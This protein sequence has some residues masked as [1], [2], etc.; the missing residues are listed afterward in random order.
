MSDFTV[1]RVD[2][3]PTSFGGGFVLARASLGVRSFGL[4]VLKM[5]PGAGG[6]EHAHRGM[7]GE[8]AE[9]ANDTRRR[10]ISVSMARRFSC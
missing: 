4:Q 8:R 3:M 2:E 10:S 7:A 6:P 9:V 1:K 5:P